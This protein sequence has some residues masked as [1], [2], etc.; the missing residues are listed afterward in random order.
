MK[1]CYCILVIILNA[2]IASVVRCQFHH[3]TTNV[4]ILIRYSIRFPF[5][6]IHFLLTIYDI[7]C[8]KTVDNTWERK[9]NN[10]DKKTKRKQTITWNQRH[11]WKKVNGNS[12]CSTFFVHLFEWKQGKRDCNTLQIKDIFLLTIAFFSELKKKIKW[13]KRSYWIKA[14]WLMTVWCTFTKGSSLLYFSLLLAT[15]L[16]ERNWKKYN[17]NRRK[18]EWNTLSIH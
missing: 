17:E 6:S 7:V 2:F 3:Q 9:R 11:N 1:L 4:E 5:D 12:N 10:E 18:K 13:K 14:G 8:Q 16:S 15:G